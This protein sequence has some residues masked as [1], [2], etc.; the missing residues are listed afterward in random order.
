MWG[1]QEH[2]VYDRQ[3]FTYLCGFRKLNGIVLCF[4]FEPKD[5]KHNDY[6]MNTASPLLIFVGLACLYYLFILFFF[7]FMF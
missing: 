7:A 1:L 3:C 5:L 2:T 4:L 6:T